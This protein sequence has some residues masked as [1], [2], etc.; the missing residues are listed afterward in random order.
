MYALFSV[1]ENCQI[2]LKQIAAETNISIRSVF[3]TIEFTIWLNLMVG[4]I[5]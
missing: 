3:S 1:A 5:K 4:G 2:I